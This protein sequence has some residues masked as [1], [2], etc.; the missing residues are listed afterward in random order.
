[1]QTSAWAL[2]GQSSEE[3]LQGC[4][5]VEAAAEY[6]QAGIPK[7]AGEA[8]DP[9]FGRVAAAASAA[10]LPEAEPWAVDAS[11]A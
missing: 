1:M 3:E 8:F 6:G 4:W 11:S 2:Q 10:G 9:A 7:V 5:S